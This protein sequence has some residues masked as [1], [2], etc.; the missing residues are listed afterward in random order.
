MSQ[1]FSAHDI[2]ISSKATLHCVSF[3]TSMRLT[4]RLENNWEPTG[5]FF[6]GKWDLSKLSSCYAG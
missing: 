2:L 6:N 3:G 1:I 4:G 5:L